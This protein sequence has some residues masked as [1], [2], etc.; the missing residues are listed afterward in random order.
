MKQT[1]TILLV[2]P[3]LLAR[4]LET[5]RPGMGAGLMME[6]M[7]RTWHC[8]RPREAGGKTYHIIFSVVIHAERCGYLLG[9]NPHEQWYQDST[10][11]ARLLGT[12][13]NSVGPVPDAW[14][15]VS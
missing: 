12:T 13:A 3:N 2:A 14:V 15:Q 4:R 5:M 11:T 9:N 1:G 10:F 8:A 7:Q 6:T